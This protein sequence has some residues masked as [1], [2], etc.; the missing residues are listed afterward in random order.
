MNFQSHH[1]QIARQ[2]RKRR[3]LKNKKKRPFSKGM[4]IRLTAEFATIMEARSKG[5][6]IFNE[7]RGK[8]FQ[9]EL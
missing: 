7:L 3:D 4:A 8:G 9:L 5:K 1:K 2:Q 6:Y